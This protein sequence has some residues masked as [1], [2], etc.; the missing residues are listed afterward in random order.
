MFLQIVML[1]SGAADYEQQ[2]AQA[3]EDHPTFFRGVVKFD[4]PLAHR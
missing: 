4:V 2:V 3:Q 1:G